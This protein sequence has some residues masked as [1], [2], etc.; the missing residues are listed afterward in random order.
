[1]MQ[2]DAQR[3]Q[4][5]QKT[6]K[7]TLIANQFS[8]SKVI[9]CVGELLTRHWNAWHSKRQCVF[10]AGGERVKLGFNSNL[11]R[12]VLLHRFV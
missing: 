11:L 12:V 10:T 6:P 4:C 2:T 5:F 1:M 7:K 9:D 8:G 3:I